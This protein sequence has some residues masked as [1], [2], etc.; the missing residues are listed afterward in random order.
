MDAELVALRPDVGE[1]IVCESVCLHCTLHVPSPQL[2]VA[3][4]ERS[5]GTVC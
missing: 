3:Q 5:V 4:L 2:S 1:Q